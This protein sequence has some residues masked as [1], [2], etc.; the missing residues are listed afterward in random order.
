MIMPEVRSF[1]PSSR[2]KASACFA[3]Y[4]S[5]VSEQFDTFAGVIRSGA[6]IVT[7]SNAA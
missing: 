5:D 4:M 7:Q 6:A 1:A 2:K 3:R